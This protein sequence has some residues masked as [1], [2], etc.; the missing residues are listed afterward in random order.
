[1]KTRYEWTSPTGINFVDIAEPSGTY[2]REGTPRPVIDALENAIHTKKRVRLFYGDK[3]TGRDWGNEYDVTGTIGRSTGNIKIPLII[4]KQTSIGGPAILVD[5]IIRLIIDGREVYRHPKYNQPEYIIKPE[6]I[7]G[8]R[9][10]V[11]ANGE[12]IARFKTKLAASRW[13]DFMTGNR[14]AK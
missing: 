5:C 9:A 6:N 11:E 14:M 8:Y 4:A 7:D 2:Y 1:M 13:V 10:R 12:T 3:E